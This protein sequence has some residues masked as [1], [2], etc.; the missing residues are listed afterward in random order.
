MP[1]K[2]PLPSKRVTPAMSVESGFGSTCPPPPSLA[3]IVTFP[4]P[5]VN[6]IKMVDE[7][8]ERPMPRAAHE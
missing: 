6:I 1:F 5:S 3:L 4:F 8:I 7:A 2:T